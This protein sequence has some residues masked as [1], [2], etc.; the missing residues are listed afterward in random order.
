MIKKKWLGLALFCLFL[1]GCGA[2]KSNLITPYQFDSSFK[3]NFSLSKKE[4]VEIPEEILETI[5]RQ[6]LEGLSEH[7]LLATTADENF[8]KA[9]VIITSYRMRPNAARL[10]VGIMAGCDNIKSNVVVIDSAT[11]QKIG[12]S[13]IM[14]KECAA[15]G[16]SS[17]VIKAYS[18]GVVKYLAGE[19]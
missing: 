15:W 19:K 18:E 9:E 14:I 8:R 17:Q 13:E 5:K 1:C 2:A 6:I 11:K 10:T 3:L 7:N 4:I 16:V 12:E